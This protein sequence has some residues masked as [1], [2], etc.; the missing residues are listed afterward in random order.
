MYKIINA[1]G[2][3]QGIFLSYLKI[4]ENLISTASVFGRNGVGFIQRKDRNPTSNPTPNPTP[5]F[6]KI[7]GLMLEPFFRMRLHYLLT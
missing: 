7:M 5:R 1:G 2:G 3:N 4:K 6:V